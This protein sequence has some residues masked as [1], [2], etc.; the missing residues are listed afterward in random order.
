MEK[1]LALSHF[2]EIFTFVRS[3]LHHEQ[4]RKASLKNST[5][6]LVFSTNH[7]KNVKRNNVSE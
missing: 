7:S 4:K 2:Q 3:F 1:G 5:P 6:W